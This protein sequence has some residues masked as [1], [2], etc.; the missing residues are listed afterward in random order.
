MV[1]IAGQPFSGTYRNEP[2]GT[3]RRGHFCVQGANK[4]RTDET[5]DGMPRQTLAGSNVREVR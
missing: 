2:S 4:A 5:L 1:A 3:D